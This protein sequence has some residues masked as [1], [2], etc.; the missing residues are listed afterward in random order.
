M[1]HQY[2]ETH[3]LESVK[4][5]LKAFRIPF[6]G[7]VEKG[8]KVEHYQS[9][10]YAVDPLTLED[11]KQ[12]IKK[13]QDDIDKRMAQ[14]TPKYDKTGKIIEDKYTVMIGQYFKK[15][16][17]R[18]MKADYEIDQKTKHA[19]QEVKKN[20]DQYEKIQNKSN[21][22]LFMKNLD[23]SLGVDNKG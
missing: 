11:Q 17:V 15:K 5:K 6:T 10:I 22:E 4:Q 21:I 1:A 23:M 2:L 16:D 7:S 14:P 8:Q 18:R 12:I 3:D 19:R 20:R 13:R 9:K